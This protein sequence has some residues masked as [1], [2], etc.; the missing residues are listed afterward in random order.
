MYRVLGIVAV[1]GLVF[2]SVTGSVAEDRD[3]FYAI[4]RG[5]NPRA[6][7]AAAGNWFGFQR[8]A[9]APA[10]VPAA[11]PVRRPTTR[12]TREARQ[13]TFAADT[14][15]RTFCV[16]T[17]DGYFFPVGPILRGADHHAQAGACA[18]MCPGAE[19]QLYSSRSGAIEDARGAGGRLYT[20][21]LTAFR[22]RGELVAGCSCQGGVT[23]GLASL[24]I[25][26]DHTLRAGDAIVTATGV[27]L[28]RTGARFPYRPRDFVTVSA[29][30]RLPTDLRRRVREIDN[31]FFEPRLP[32]TVARRSAAGT[33]A[34]APRLDS[35]REMMAVRHIA[36]TR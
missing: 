26:R 14:V 13:A 1:S 7:R 15:S 35:V 32:A 24:P 2:L 4:A 33:Y 6:P 18:A 17:C 16:R 5:E 29:Y 3:E 19:V 30:G 10:A 8:R 21:S 34:R 20:A 28:M 23:R 22:H 27:R 25:G 9:E 31:A 36:I 11:A 12:Q